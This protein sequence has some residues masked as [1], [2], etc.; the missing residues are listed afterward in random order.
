MK[1]INF[2]IRVYIVFSFQI[3]GFSQA[4]N[5]TIQSK[6]DRIVESRELKHCAIS[7]SVIDIESGGQV[8]EHNAE[9]AVIPASSLKVLTTLSSLELLK[10]TFRF[11]T[12]LKYEGSIDEEGNLNG[13]LYIIGG[14][15]PTLGSNKWTD[16]MM[17]DNLCQNLIEA[18]KNEGITCIKGDIIADE[19]IYPSFPISPSWQWNDLG[20]YYASG[21]WGINIHEN[22]YHLYFD[23]RNIV[24]RQPRIKY[25]HPKINNLKFSNEVVVDSAGT[26]DQAYIFGGPYNFKKRIVGTIPQGTT[27][28]RIKGSIP[29]PPIFFA[30]YLS[31]QLLKNG[32]QSEGVKTNFYPVFKKRKDIITIQ[33]PP[34]KEIVK[35]ANFESNNLYC[36][37][38]LKYMGLEY[39]GGG[40]GQNGIA[41]IR[42]ILRKFDIPYDGLHME[43][44]SGLSARNNVTSKLLSQF[45]YKYSEKNGIEQL[46]KYLPKAGYQGTVKSLLKSSKAKGR[47]YVKSGSMNRVQSYVGVVQNAQ[48]QWQ[49][50]A[51][52]FNGFTHKNSVISSKLAKIIDVIYRG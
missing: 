26:G 40:T 21:A 8:A 13:N 42:S 45:L 1:S 35:R 15:D 43:D 31:K 36:E 29:D 34:L 33:S 20:N 49:S 4:A 3:F 10:D 30:E 22:E 5:P 18:I 7:I 24:G 17:I 23:E 41:A 16:D 9:M 32:I 11:K 37:A 28:F 12:E 25:H 2:F 6:I 38:I 39:H 44:G 47:S 46:I 50:F 14:G 51:I 52:L 48:G 27:P 19:S